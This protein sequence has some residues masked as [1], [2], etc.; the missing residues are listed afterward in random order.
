MLL[1]LQG[2]DSS[3][4]KYNG[5]CAKLPGPEYLG[6]S[7]VQIDMPDGNTYDGKVCFCQEDLCNTDTS[8]FSQSFARTID[9]SPGSFNMYNSM[10]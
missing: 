6:C 7:D 8:Q 1:Y 2:D 3:P 9:A 4:I 10:T 5:R